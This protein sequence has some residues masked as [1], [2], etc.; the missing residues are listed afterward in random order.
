MGEEKLGKR[1]ISASWGWKLAKLGKNCENLEFTVRKMVLLTIDHVFMYPKWQ[2]HRNVL[3][4][5][6]LFKISSPHHIVKTKKI[7]ND[8]QTEIV[9]IFS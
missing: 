1:L 8:T 6:L 3:S 4:I 7:D 5:Y 2:T 9:K